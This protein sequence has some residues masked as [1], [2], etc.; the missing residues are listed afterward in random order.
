MNSA[1]G[2]AACLFALAGTALHAQGGAAPSADASLTRI[3]A[4][5]S[6]ALAAIH[7]CACQWSVDLDRWNHGKVEW[8]ERA[9]IEM[10]FIGDREVW[11]WPGSGAF[12]SR[13]LTEVFRSGAMSTGNLAII[14]YNVFFADSA[15]ISRDGEETLAGARTLR[16]RFNVPLLSSKMTLRMVNEELAVPYGGTFWAD[17]ATFALRRMEI[18]AEAPGINVV[19]QV[20]YEQAALDGTS[21]YVPA[22]VQMT[23]TGVIGDRSRFAMKRGACHRFTA[24]S[25]LSFGDVPAAAGPATPAPRVASVPAGLSLNLKLA[26]EIDSEN[27]A[28]GDPV[29][30]W[31]DRA[32]E[33]G[34]LTLAKRSPIT[35]RITHVH[36]SWTPDRSVQL[37]LAFDTAGS[38]EAPL[39]LHCDLTLR[40][41]PDTRGTLDTGGL[42]GRVAAPARGPDLIIS[43]NTLRKTGGR[44]ILERGFSLLCTT[45]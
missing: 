24:A 31:L 17:P 36:E 27:A 37:G 2:L 30:A 25:A 20:D 45:R 38:P 32:V 21:A 43:D 8:R 44:L 29:T 22:R 19:G 9:R 35:G 40:A 26:G 4:Q 6:D 12:E 3:R 5:A 13:E 41:R 14:L 39:A 28:A 15:T 33:A 23:A 7:N 11:A 10:A 42:A 1:Y 34:P 16:Y 18:R